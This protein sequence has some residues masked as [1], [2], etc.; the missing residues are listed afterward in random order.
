MFFLGYPHS[1]H[2][3]AGNESKEQEQGDFTDREKPKSTCRLG[4]HGVSARVGRPAAAFWFSQQ[5]TGFRLK[6]AGGK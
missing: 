6:Q 3:Q 2:T 4:G 1:L 5:N